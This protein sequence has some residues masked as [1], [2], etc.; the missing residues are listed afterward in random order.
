MEGERRAADLDLQHMAANLDSHNKRLSLLSKEL[1][2][3]VKTRAPISVTNHV[4]LSK[5]TLNWT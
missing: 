4:I 1:G 3:E 5:D 2:I